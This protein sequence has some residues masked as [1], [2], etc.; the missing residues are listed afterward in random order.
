[1]NNTIMR[2]RGDKQ[3]TCGALRPAALRQRLTAASWRLAQRRLLHFP[4][5]LQ[6]VS[7]TVAPVR[8]DS[9]TTSTLSGRRI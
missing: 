9:R 6:I 2:L 5:F 3:P 8:I 1:M 7:P 4:R